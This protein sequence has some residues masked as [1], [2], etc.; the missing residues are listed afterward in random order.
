[1]IHTYYLDLVELTGAL[2]FLVAFK[3]VMLLGMQKMGSILSDEPAQ[4]K[5]K[6]KPKLSKDMNILRWALV[7]GIVLAAVWQ[8]RPYMLSVTTSQLVALGSFAGVAHWW[9][10]N[11]LWL[12]IWSVV[13]ELAFA[14]SFVS[15]S[16]PVAVRVT[17]TLLLVYSVMVWVWLQGFGHVFGAV[18]S[19]LIGVPGTGLLIAVCALPLVLPGRTW[20]RAF[21]YFTAAYWVLFCAFQWLPS[22]HFWGGKGYATLATVQSKALPHGLSG[23][24]SGVLNVM[25]SSGALWTAGLGVVA[26][27]LAAG[28]LFYRSQWM[29]IASAVVLLLVWVFVQGFGLGG[30]YVFAFGT[31]PFAALIAFIGRPLPTDKQ[32]VAQ[33]KGVAV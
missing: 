4:K 27:G 33:R 28:A 31:A 14:A 18:S 21:A 16:S 32:S 1:M 10:V 30:G 19:L 26:L 2:V 6:D 5:A 7:G 24:V 11:A 22:N 17:A 13:I 20:Q 29:P 9:V 12:N 25:A 3:V 23:M 8:I 15:F